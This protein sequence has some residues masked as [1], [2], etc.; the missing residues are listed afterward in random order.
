MEMPAHSPPGVE[1][2]LLTNSPASSDSAITQAFFIEAWPAVKAKV[3]R[4]R[5]LVMA[6][7]RKLH[8][9]CAV[10]D[11]VVSVVGTYNLDFLSAHVN[12]EVGAAV[13]SP[14]VAAELTE[15]IRG[16]LIDAS[17]MIK[18]YTI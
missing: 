2:V 12:S 18:E 4:L 16:D 9:K 5:V 15:S 11:D 14:A 17:N 10:I 1:I 13:W 8:A 3:P 6:G 7:K